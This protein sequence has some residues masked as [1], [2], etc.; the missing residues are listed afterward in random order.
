VWHRHLLTAVDS[1]TLCGGCTC[2]CALCLGMNAAA[3]G[4]FLLGLEGDCKPTR[5]DC[6]NSAVFDRLGVGVGLVERFIILLVLTTGRV[7]DFVGKGGLVVG[8]GEDG[9]NGELEGSLLELA[10]MVGVAER[11][12][13]FAGCRV[14]MIL[15]E[16]GLAGPKTFL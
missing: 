10:L 16:T 13:D 15:G 2:E 6:G 5:N 14:L 4:S 11:A 3:S 7:G 1:S 12:R 9:K 8:G